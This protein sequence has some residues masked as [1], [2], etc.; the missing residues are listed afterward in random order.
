MK[1]SLSH[2]PKHKQEELRYITEFICS[3]SKYADMLILFGSYARGDWVEDIHTEG[4]TTHV[5]ES[6]FDILVA[7]KSK[8]TAEDTDLHDRVE[9]AID[10]T[11]KV[12]DCFMK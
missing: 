6:D 11:N 4:H 5:Y 7:T 10:A 9:K 8:K 2:L 12:G 1:K 3:K